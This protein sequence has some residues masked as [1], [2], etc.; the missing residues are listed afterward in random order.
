MRPAA[1]GG[2]S[3]LPAATPSG[4]G[5]G[6]G[7]G[8]GGAADGAERGEPE[9]EAAA[10]LVVFA[11]PVG[12]APA[13]PAAP[14][15]GAAV[16]GVGALA[17]ASGPYPVPAK[18]RHHGG[19]CRVRAARRWRARRKRRA[20][21]CAAPRL[22]PS[23]CVLFTRALTPPRA[24]LPARPQGK[25]ATAEEIRAVQHLPLRVAA[26][27]C[28]LGTTQARAQCAARK[29]AAADAAL[30]ALCC[31]LALV[32]RL[33]LAPPAQFKLQCRALGITR[34]PYR[35]LQA[36]RTTIETCRAA[37][38]DD[39]RAGGASA[40]AAG[41]A[42]ASAGPAALRGRPAAP[43]PP[44][45]ASSSAAGAAAPAPAHRL[46]PPGGESAPSSDPAGWVE[47]LEALQVGPSRSFHV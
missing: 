8:G 13:A 42:G 6:G 38:R 2:R 16:G 10:A 28:G 30:T 15:G 36:L 37:A 26:D 47:R 40:G 27:R 17:P 4:A 39:A 1:T 11:L 41:A 19:R 43:L 31:R 23:P 32:L 25:Q 24:A 33:L 35:K 5:G 22:C 7:G 45:G 18:R 21:P 46:L 14:A 12:G 29:C 34:W 20:A 44:P 9:T 3:S